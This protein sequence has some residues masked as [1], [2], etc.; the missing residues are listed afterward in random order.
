MLVSD[1]GL[2]GV[3]LNLAELTTEEEPHPLCGD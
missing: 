1:G 2:G 3:R